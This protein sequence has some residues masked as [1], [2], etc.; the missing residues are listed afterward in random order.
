M[1][2]GS[3][4]FEMTYKNNDFTGPCRLTYLDCEIDGYKEQSLLDRLY[5]SR[6]D[7]D[8][9]PKVEPEKPKPSGG[10]YDIEFKDVNRFE[11]VPIENEDNKEKK[12][13]PWYVSAWLKMYRCFVDMFRECKG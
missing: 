9:K 6:I 4:A 10:G 8:D 12:K 2:K 5:D 11:L 13:Q 7:I 3:F 1:P